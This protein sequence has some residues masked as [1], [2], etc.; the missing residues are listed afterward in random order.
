MTCGLGRIVVRRQS[1]IAVTLALSA[2]VAIKW[3][4]QGGGTASCSFRCTGR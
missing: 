3:R 2:T 4:G 1:L